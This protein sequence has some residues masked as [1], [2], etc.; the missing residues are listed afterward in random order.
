MSDL[1]DRQA[2]IDRINKQ[3]EHLQPNIYEQDYIG[4]AAYKICAEFIERL[5]STQPKRGRW[6]KMS[7]SFG[8]YYAC[9]CCGEDCTPH[10]M[11]T[12]FCPS[13][14]AEMSEGGQDE[15]N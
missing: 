7:N 8:T 10:G 15:Q 5:P 11:K 9:N 1:I 14:G 13:C 6:V 4:D 3:R 2:A 12:P